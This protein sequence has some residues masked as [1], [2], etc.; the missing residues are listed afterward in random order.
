MVSK[1]I[2]SA[3]EPHV[4]IFFY[5][6][7][8]LH[9]ES[10]PL[11]QAEQ[12]GEDILIHGGDHKYYWE[13]TL[14]QSTPGHRDKS[15]DFFPRGRVAYSIKDAK[16]YLYH[17]ICIPQTQ[18]KEVMAIMNLPEPPATVI[19]LDGNYRCASCNGNYVSDSIWEQD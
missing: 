2:E 13:N 16:F 15:Y 17:D 4:G 9:I 14:A 1:S 6:N 18:I 3:K 19:D 11:S 10:T 12:R 5:A 7:S 8:S